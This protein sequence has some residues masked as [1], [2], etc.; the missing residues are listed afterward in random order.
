MDYKQEKVYSNSL[1]S[2]IKRTTEDGIFFSVVRWGS[3]FFERTFA[4]PTQAIT[5]CDKAKDGDRKI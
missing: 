5:W 4:S 1:Y 2:V 3:P